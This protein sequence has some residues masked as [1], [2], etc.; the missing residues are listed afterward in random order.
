M[1]I[2]GAEDEIVFVYDASEGDIKDF[3][4]K[5]FLPY[6][7][8]MGCGSPDRFRTEPQLR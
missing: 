6:V 3:W 7:A 4:V 5:I 2:A 8:G 1:H